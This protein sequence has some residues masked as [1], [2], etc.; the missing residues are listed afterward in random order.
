MTCFSRPV[1][2]AKIRQVY[3]Q[4]IEKIAGRLLKVYCFLAYRLSF[5]LY[6]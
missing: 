3:G 2:V 5:S 6:Y 1:R 4:K